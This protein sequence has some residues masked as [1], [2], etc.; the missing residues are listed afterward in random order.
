M[1]GT[2]Y[3]PVGGVLGMTGTRY[4]PL[5]GGYRKHPVLG[6]P[7]LRGGTESGEAPQTA[8]YPPGPMPV[9]PVSPARGPAPGPWAQEELGQHFSTPLLRISKVSYRW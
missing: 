7:P 3:P 6:T 5:R 4:P 9:S 2:R 1:T 8:I